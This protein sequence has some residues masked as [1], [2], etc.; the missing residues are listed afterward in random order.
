M[1]LMVL[2]VDNKKYFDFLSGYSAI[3]QG[4]CHPKV[5]RSTGTTAHA[6]AAAECPG[7]GAG[8]CGVGRPA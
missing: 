5:R 6:A 1:V 4:H 2:Q 8:D 3:N 7:V